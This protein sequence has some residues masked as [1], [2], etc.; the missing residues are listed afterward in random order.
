MDK[1]L[2][3]SRYNEDVSW[4]KDLDI[5][6]LIYNKGEDLD[7]SYNWVRKENV[8]ENQKDIFSFIVDNY[9]NLPDVV[10]FCQGFPFDHCKKETFVNL[11]KNN[12]LTRLEDYSHLIPCNNVDQDGYYFEHNDNWYIGAH[13]ASRNQTC[14]FSSFDEYMNSLF[15]NYSHLD[16]LT[17]SPGSQIIVEKERILHYPKPFWNHLNNMLNRI[18]MTEGHI[19]ERSLFLIFSNVYDVREEF[20]NEL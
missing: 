18:S 15:S 19:I 14:Q 3:I 5:D 2:I 10:A 16:R 6:Y 8:G 11:I 7:S 17:F 9:E 20:K 1:I 12:T 4:A 13:N